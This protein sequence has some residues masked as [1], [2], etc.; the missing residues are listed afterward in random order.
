M[1][2]AIK[3]IILKT[4]EEIVIFDVSDETL[5]MAGSGAREQG[6]FTLGGCTGLSDCPA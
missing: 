5:E 4:E 6:N 1:V 3:D 2:S